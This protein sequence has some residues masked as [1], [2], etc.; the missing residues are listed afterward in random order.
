M[1]QADL[2]VATS[3]DPCDGLTGLAAPHYTLLSRREAP[4]RWEGW[5]ERRDQPG[6]RHGGA[7]GCCRLFSLWLWRPSL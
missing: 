7:D 1:R 6:E 2:P 3:Y 4:R 5:H